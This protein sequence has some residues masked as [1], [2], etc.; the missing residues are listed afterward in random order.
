MLKDGEELNDGP[1]KENVEA[2]EFVY[3]EGITRMKYGEARYL[4]KA[5]GVDTRA[6]RD[7]SFVGGSVCSLLTKKTY[8]SDLIKLF[9]YEGSPLKVL[10]NFDPMSK[11]HFKRSTLPSKI[12]SPMDIF[13]KRAASAVANN[14]RLEVA[15]KYQCQL[16]AEYREKLRLEVQKILEARKGLKR[17]PKE[18]LTAPTPVVVGDSAPEG[19]GMDTD[20]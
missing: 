2:L 12:A 7:I 11:T 8:K 4:L 19:E 3:V 5:A 20:P 6:I 14:R 13:I 1:L 10:E 9:T 16:P 18:G 15:T 17:T